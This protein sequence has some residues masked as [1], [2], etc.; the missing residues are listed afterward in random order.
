MSDLLTQLLAVLGGL[1][2]VGVAFSAGYRT[3]KRTAS[4]KLNSEREL[5]RFSE[6]YAPCIGLFT[7]HH[8]TT[9]SS[10]AAPYFSQRWR[11]ALELAGE[12][13]WRGAFHALFDKQALPTTGEVEF[14]ADFPLDEITQILQGKEQFADD[15]LVNLVRRANRAQYENLPGPGRLTE[16]DIELL[17]HIEIEHAKLCKRFVVAQQ[18]D[19]R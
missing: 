9:V 7:T 8:V 4:R 1:G 19:Q 3:G 6:I 18:V 12:F 16:V 17:E 5:R 13:R 11:N 2:V 14:G 10:Q 15:R